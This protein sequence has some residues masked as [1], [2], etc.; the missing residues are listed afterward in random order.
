MLTLTLVPVCECVKNVFDL[1]KIQ[2]VHVQ[3]STVSTA[4]SIHNLS[5]T[6][7][8]LCALRSI[9]FQLMDN[10]LNLRLGIYTCLTLIGDLQM[11]VPSIEFICVEM[12]KLHE[13]HSTNHYAR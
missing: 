6:D 13:V 8:E 3:Y 9:Q 4:A 10:I 2:L 11:Y 12:K 7:F 5:L 1:T